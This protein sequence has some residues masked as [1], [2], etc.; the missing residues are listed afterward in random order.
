MLATIERCWNSE[1]REFDW[2]IWFD[3]KDQI[4]NGSNQQIKK[5]AQSNFEHIGRRQVELINLYLTYM[6]DENNKNW[7]M[8][9]IKKREDM[10]HFLLDTIWQEEFYSKNT[11]LYNEVLQYRTD[12]FDYIIYGNKQLT[13]AKLSNMI[14]QGEAIYIVN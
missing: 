14:K 11:K 2:L 13:P 5:S 6:K 12:V 1:T 7:A 8:N 3:S 10:V 9:E 4:F